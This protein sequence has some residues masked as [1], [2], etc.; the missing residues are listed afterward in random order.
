MASVTL[1]ILTGRI[2][3]KTPKNYGKRSMMEIS[4][5]R[6]GRKTKEKISVGRY[7]KFRLAFAAKKMENPDIHYGTAF[8][9]W[10]NITTDSD[11]VSI[12][13]E[14]LT[15]EYIRVNYIRRLPKSKTRRKRIKDHIEIM[16]RHAAGSQVGWQSKIKAAREYAR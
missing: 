12:A 16:K 5:I 4:G 11:L 15:E 6:T 8:A 9:S 14:W 1:A 2:A 13:S 10:F 7:K 3:S